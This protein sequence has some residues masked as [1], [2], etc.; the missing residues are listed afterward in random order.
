MSTYAVGDIQGCYKHLKRLLKQ[1]GFSP[2]A[3]RLWCVGDMINRGPHSLDTLRFL[4]DLQPA[5]VLVLGNHDLH[6]LAVYEGCTTPRSKDTLDELLQAPDCADLAEWL[7]HKPLA[8][9]ETVQTRK[10]LKRFLMVHAGVAPSWSLRTTLDLAAEVEGAL[11]GEDYRGYLTNMYGDT[12]VRWSE[13]LEG[14]ER[15]RTITNYLTRVR[16]CDEAGSLRL[17]VKEGYAGAPAGY[18][19]WFE[20]QRITPEVKIV[21][22]HWAAIEGKTERE[23]VIAL[24][25]GCVW[26]RELTM[27]RLEDGKR[28]SVSA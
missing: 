22:G 10:G 7:R 2:A 12:P 20:F 8:H 5:P 3:D 1:A 21:F 11:Q 27:M 17:D 14:Y 18:R 26:G 16:F 6:F 13:A 28:F 19:P 24:D 15:L 9:H 4:Q 23:D 25:T